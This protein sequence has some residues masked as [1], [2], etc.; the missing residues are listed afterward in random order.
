MQICS[1]CSHGLG[2]RG[3]QD[4]MVVSRSDEVIG[5]IT[6]DGVTRMVVTAIYACRA[7]QS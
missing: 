4:I 2:V 5:K 6:D 7:M 1:S 3:R